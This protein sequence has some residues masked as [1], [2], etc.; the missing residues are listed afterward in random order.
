MKNTSG[1]TP[2]IK[3]RGIMFALGI[4]LLLI[5]VVM[6]ICLRLKDHQSTRNLT[7]LP[8]RHR[9]A[10]LELIRLKSQRGFV[11]SGLLIFSGAVIVLLTAV[12]N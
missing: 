3:V 1:V 12:F 6:R 2:G 9:S 4:V 7:P 5:G 8:V 10:Q 11:D